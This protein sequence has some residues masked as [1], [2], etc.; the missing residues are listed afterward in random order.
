V[1][2]NVAAN[3]TAVGALAGIMWTKI[4]REKGLF[5]S[6]KRF[7]FFGSITMIPLASL[8]VLILLAQVQ[9]F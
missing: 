4:I 1:A 9:T 7:F 2:S 3:F 6:P 5:V 8:F